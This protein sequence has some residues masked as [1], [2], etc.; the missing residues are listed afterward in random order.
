MWRERAPG[1][2]EAC[3]RPR[4]VCVK[5]FLGKFDINA[6]F[7]GVEGSK[8]TMFDAMRF[9]LIDIHESQQYDALIARVQSIVYKDVSQFDNTE[10]HGPG[11]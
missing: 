5:Q 6:I 11:T 2:C 10:N 3:R 4:L 7:T 1:F 8:H 9:L